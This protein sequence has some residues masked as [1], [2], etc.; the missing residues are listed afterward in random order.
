MNIA[1]KRVTSDPFVINDFYEKLKSEAKR[2]NIMGRPEC[3]WNTDKT[4]F[5]TDPSLVKAIGTIGVRSVRVT[6]GSNRENITVLATCCGSGKVLPP[7]V[8]FKGTRILHSWVTN[9]GLP[10]TDYAVSNNGWMTRQ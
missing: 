7:L 1:R 10:G 2:L 8:I 3:F 9:K 4:S 6:A 5:P